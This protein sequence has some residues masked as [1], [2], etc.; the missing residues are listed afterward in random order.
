MSLASFTRWKASTETAAFGRYSRSARRNDAEGS[1]STAS[2]HARLRASS[3]VPTQAE[4]RGVDH[5]EHPAGVGV[6]QRGHPPQKAALD[7]G[8]PNPGRGAHRLPNRGDRRGVVNP[9]TCPRSL[10]QPSATAAVVFFCFGSS[11]SA[12]LSG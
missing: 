12:C 9:R 6:D 2:R 8:P 5:A 11:A 7:A 3:Q 10:T 4:F 1:T